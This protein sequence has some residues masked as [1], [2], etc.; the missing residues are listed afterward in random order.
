MSTKVFT[1]VV[2]VGIVA[3][4]FGLVEAVVVVYL[5]EIYYPHGFAFPLASLSLNH[6]SVEISRE[7][8]TI[9]ILAGLGILAGSSR[10]QRFGFFLVSFAVWDV[11]YYIW[12]KVLL[13][14]PASILDWDVLFL[15]PIPWIG[16]VL[17][18]VII[19]IALLGAGLAILVH[20]DRSQAFV[21]GRSEAMV[22]LIATCVLLY[23]F[24][25]DLQATL[26]GDVP[27]P[28]KYLLF[29]AGMA[30][31][32]TVLARMVMRIPRSS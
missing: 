8:A 14:W 5:R 27:Q 25:S 19:S 7:A 11:F 22:T 20:E 28:Y 12:L 18:P 13:D 3:V 10:W 17:A 26:H 1:R 23:T 15:I 30:G 6:I 21:F 9:V 24:V 31:Y 4:A 32:G 2:W 29:I 16:P